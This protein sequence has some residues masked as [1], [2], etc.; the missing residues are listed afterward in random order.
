MNIKEHIS[1]ATT[2]SELIQIMDKYYLDCGYTDTSSMWGELGDK[3]GDENLL[4][5]NQRWYE[6]GN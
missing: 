2:N 4:L 6:L 1:N 3:L 5:A